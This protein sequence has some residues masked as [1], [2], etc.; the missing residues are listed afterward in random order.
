MNKILNDLGINDKL[1]K[2]HPP[3]QKKFNKVKN[4]TVMME[5]MNYMADL[6]YL[7]TTKEGYKYCLCIVDLATN[8][9]DIEPLKKKDA[10]ATLEE[11]KNIF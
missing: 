11:M 1:N 9:F 10:P 7:P 8:V 2:F 4:N 5:G 6:V 3:K